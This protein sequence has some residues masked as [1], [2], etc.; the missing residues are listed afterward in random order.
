[1]M[2]RWE[3]N[4]GS[5]EVQNI[6]ENREDH[7]SMDRGWTDR[8]Q[9]TNT[10]MNDTRV[11]L[12]ELSWHESNEWSAQCLVMFSQ[13]KHKYKGLKTFGMKNRQESNIQ[14]CHLI[15]IHSSPFLHSPSSTRTVPFCL[16]KAI[17]CP[18]FQIALNVLSSSDSTSKHAPPTASV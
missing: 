1:M 2:G 9:R 11:R 12:V 6:S 4:S 16:L 3:D 5:A 10:I 7:R 15:R 14:Y 18:Q 17:F 13:Y 8:Q